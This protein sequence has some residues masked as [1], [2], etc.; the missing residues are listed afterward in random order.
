MHSAGAQ[1]QTV[2]A[3]SMAGTVD[4]AAPEQMGRLPG[5]STG[6]YSDVYGF[7]KTCCYALFQTPQPLPRHWEEVPRSLARL[8]AACLEEAPERRPADFGVVLERLQRVSEE[9]TQPLAVVQADTAARRPKAG[10]AGAVGER[11]RPRESGPELV[12]VKDVGS[13]PRIRSWAQQTRTRPAP[14]SG[15]FWLWVALA[16][17]M[18]AM[19]VGGVVVGALALMARPNLAGGPSGFTPAASVSRTIAGT[20]R[21][22]GNPYLSRFECDGSKYRTID[23]AGLLV[24]MGTCRYTAGDANNGTLELHYN[25]GLERWSVRWVGDNQIECHCLQHPLPMWL[26]TT[27]RWQR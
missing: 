8:L 22:A 24:G 15:R 26:G 11:D 9:L 7:G 20:W 13:A 6:P 23:R 21:N 5:R 4:Y 2:A 16:V 17:G 10:K 25:G 3:S 27:L 14:P 1:R 19:L 18:G 12:G